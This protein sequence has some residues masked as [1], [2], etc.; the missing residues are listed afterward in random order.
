[1][2]REAALT[3]G[4]YAVPLI[5][6]ILI[7]SGAAYLCG[8]KKEEQHALLLCNLLTNPLLN[9]I[10]YAKHYATGTGVS[11]PAVLLLEAAVVL[12]EGFLLR[13]LFQSLVEWLHL[14]H[15][16]LRVIVASAGIVPGRDGSSPPP[17]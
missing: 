12:G 16:I 2:L 3:L 8:L 4:Y 10:L 14:A 17:R 15:L 6:T 5:L 13:P 7:E 11:L 1:M 9:L